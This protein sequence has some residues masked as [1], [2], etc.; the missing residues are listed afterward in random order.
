VVLSS[1]PAQ[2][3]EETVLKMQALQRSLAGGSA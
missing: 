3:Y 2:E 1:D